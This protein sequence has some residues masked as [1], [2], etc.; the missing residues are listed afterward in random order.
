MFEPYDHTVA[1]DAAGASLIK[2]LYRDMLMIVLVRH[3]QR[4][5]PRIDR[6]PGKSLTAVG[7]RQAK[8]AAKCVAQLPL[9]HIYTSDMARAFQ[10]AT[11]LKELRPDVPFTPLSDIR[12]L[13]VADQPDDYP[14]D[15]SPDERE[16]LHCKRINRFVD[17][18]RRDHQPGE[19]LAVVCHGAFIRRLTARLAGMPDGSMIEIA[20][21]NAS[22]TLLSISAE[23]KMTIRLT[24]CTRHLTPGQI[25]GDNLP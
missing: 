16:Q 4:G 3:G 10:T 22:I 23:G 19:V 17:R 5:G 2:R 11:P 24:N 18:L 7:H 14:P 21:H 1:T 20:N 25:I 15:L 8:R 9:T 6:Y 13:G 12:E